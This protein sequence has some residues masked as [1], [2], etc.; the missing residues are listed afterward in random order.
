MKCL[1]AGTSFH[2]PKINLAMNKPQ[3]KKRFTALLIAN[4][5]NKEIA[6]LYEKAIASG[7]ISIDGEPEESY[8]MPIIIYYAIM[9]EMAEKW[10][11]LDHRNRKAADNLRHFL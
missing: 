6:S 7:S 5:P 9:C 8:R 11:P 4:D 1:L 3:L 2:Q 10:K